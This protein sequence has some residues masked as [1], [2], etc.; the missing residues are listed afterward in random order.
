M[1]KHQAAYAAMNIFIKPLLGSQSYH[2]LGV[3][4]GF[5]T[6]SK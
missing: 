6:N 3:V 5:S 2:L 4:I 1:E